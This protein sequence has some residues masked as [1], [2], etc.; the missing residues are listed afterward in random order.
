MDKLH[1]RKEKL[2]ALI[3]ELERIIE[4]AEGQ[5]KL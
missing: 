4:K 3:N 2:D 1:K 5:K